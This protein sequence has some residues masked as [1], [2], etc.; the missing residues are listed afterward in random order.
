M[1]AEKT[2][3]RR[4]ES[5]LKPL[6][7][8]QPPSNFVAIAS[9]TPDDEHGDDTKPIRDCSLRRTGDVRRLHLPDDVWPA[10]AAG[11]EVAAGHPARVRLRTCCSNARA[12]RILR[13]LVYELP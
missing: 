5:N 3:D 12:S 7:I 9:L 13:C 6:I 8:E 11:K 4:G 1:I 2:N 10:G